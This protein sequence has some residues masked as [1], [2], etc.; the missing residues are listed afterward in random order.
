LRFEGLPCGSVSKRD[1]LLRS[2]ASFKR[3]F[4]RPHFARSLCLLSVGFD[5]AEFTGSRS[6]RTRLEKQHRP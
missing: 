4:P 5:P 3:N 1:I 2:S 6:E